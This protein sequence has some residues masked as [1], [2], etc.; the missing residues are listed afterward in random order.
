[1][2]LPPGERDNGTG[3]DGD[4]AVSELVDLAQEGMTGMNRKTPLVLALAFCAALPLAALPA[5]ASEPVSAQYI[6]GKLVPI[7]GEEEGRSIDL[8]INF[9]LNSA[10]LTPEAEQQLDALGTAMISPELSYAQF[11]IYGHT[12]A[13]GSAEYNKTLSEKRAESVKTYLV[14]KFDI[15]PDRL[16]TAGYGEE[17][18][19]NAAN[20]NAAE[21][22]RV[23]IVNRTPLKGKAVP[24]APQAMPQAPQ[25]VPQVPETMPQAAPNSTPG[26]PTAPP[27]VPSEGGMQVIN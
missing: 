6:I 21:N 8:Q 27:Q 17:K 10:R 2:A 23:Q 26:L 7:T 5:S 9:E 16:Y 24:Q 4:F 1:M 14:G 19:K 13:S 22:R 12:D 18:L 20:P 3:D 15:A 25:A 11:S